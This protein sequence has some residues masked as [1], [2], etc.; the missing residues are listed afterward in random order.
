MTQRI[1]LTKKSSM[2]QVGRC[3]VPIPGCARTVSVTG[4]RRA[5]SGCRCLFPLQ[6]ADAHR[7][8]CQIRD[9]TSPYPVVTTKMD[10]AAI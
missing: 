8:K 1:T 5:R 9:A 6:L 3:I 4:S 10:L 2:T 7:P